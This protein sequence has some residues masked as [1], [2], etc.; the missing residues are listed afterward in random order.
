[1]TKI[2]DIQITSLADYFSALE[3][4]KPG[5]TVT[6]TVHRNKTDRTVRVTLVQQQS[7]N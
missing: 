5:D 3:D 7:G 1:M 4:K 6:V 2:D